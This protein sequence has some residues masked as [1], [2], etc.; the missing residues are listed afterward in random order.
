MSYIRGRYSWLLRPALIFFDVTIIVFFASYFIDFKTFGLPYWS[1]GFLKSKATFFVFYASILW[2]ISAYSI[3]FYNVYRYTTAL[4]ILGLLI[5]QFLIF[6]IIVFAFIGFYRGIE[7][8]KITVL[9][10]LVISISVIACVKF[11][12]F[13]GLK[14]YRQHLNGNHRRVLIIG[15]T[16][17]AKDLKHFFT[18]KSEYGY[19]LLGVY[20]NNSS[21]SPNG[22]IQDAVNFISNNNSIDEIYCA[23]DELSENEINT[24][25]KYAELNQ[26][27]IKFIPKRANFFNKRL[28]TDFYNYLPVLS[29]QEV[30]LNKPFNRV[31]KRIFDVVF[32]IL[33]IVFILSW[34]SVILF[35]LIKLESKGPLFYKHKRNG[36][37]YKEF[38]C[39]K[40]RSLR[41]DS[42]EANDYVK[43]EDVRVTK[44][45]R[46]LRQTSLDELPQFINVFKGDMSVVGPRPHMISY[47]E[48]YSKK[49]DTYNF[50]FRHNVKPGVT[51]LAQVKG[52]RG[53]VKT[54]EDI[55][56]RVK[57]DI[58]YI[59]NWSVL[60]DLDIIG[61]TMIG[62]LKGDEKAY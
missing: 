17:G 43:K 24:F 44:I 52:F 13:F 46:F 58:F 45:G 2:L 12:M 33:V 38:N 51:G 31:L 20:S 48:A 25:V 11:L 1:I 62:V 57:Y 3:K 61:K 26:C 9:K 7:I 42:T 23:M 36:I 16:E 39:Y 37:N 49:I 35:V 22:N 56:N 59:E 60:L 5:K 27:N 41:K 32:S 18:T 50:I 30:S 34:L 47:T 19:D 54:D 40:F 28:K 29:I 4:N 10:Y 8:N 55:I 53:E 15:S 21:Q 14:K 6:F